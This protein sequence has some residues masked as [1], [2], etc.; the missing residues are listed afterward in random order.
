MK[1]NRIAVVDCDNFFVSCERA[2]D[3]SLQGKAVCVLGNNE[4]CI[5]A[6]SNE[7][8]KL[9]VPM[10]YPYF[11]AIKEYPNVIYI[12]GNHILY[13]QTSK[14]VFELLKTYTPDIEQYSIDEGFFDISKIRKM[15]GKNDCEIAQTIREDILN[16]LKIPVSIGIAPTKTL[17]KMA[18]EIAKKTNGINDFDDENLMEFLKIT[19]LEQIWGIGKNSFSKLQNFGIN[20]AYDLVKQDDFWIQKLLTKRG[21]DL[22][23]ELLGEIRNPINPVPP[24]PKSLQS[25]RT[26]AKSTDDKK[27]I[28]LALM[29]HLSQLCTKLRENNLKANGLEVILKDKN[30]VYSTQKIL[31]K[32][33]FN[34]VLE[35]QKEMFKLFDLIWQ[36][37]VIY[38]SCGICV[39]NIS[40]TEATQ[41]GLLDTQENKKYE[42]LTQTMDKIQ[43]KF[44][45]GSVKLGR[46]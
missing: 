35:V 44:G 24:I 1:K 32:K 33:S 46:L 40:Q 39:Y 6:R 13:K 16:K 20:T 9:G 37:N 38:R 45:K 14:K 7:A 19:K 26:F 28:K 18:T 34:S 30:F 5:V 3:E 41:M 25:T 10:G 11:K 36:K 8:K 22:K 2:I 12:A 15:L 21:L 29:G 27:E 4:S 31:L 17:A 43:K 42:Q 23:Y